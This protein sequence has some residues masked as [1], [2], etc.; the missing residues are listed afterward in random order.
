M[1]TAT[2]L[3]GLLRWCGWQRLE[4]KIDGCQ[5]LIG[6]SAV[7]RPGHLHRVEL[8]AGG[9]HAGADCLDEISLRPSREVTARGEV[10]ASRRTLLRLF[11][12]ATYQPLPV[13]VGTH[14]YLSQV[15]ASFLSDSI[16]G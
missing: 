7:G 13:A 12:R 14:A 1:L 11:G 3:V 4:V 2:R 8:V 10:G 5:I 16:W 15:V 6:K 9:G